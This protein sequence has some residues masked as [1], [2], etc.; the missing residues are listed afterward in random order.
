MSRRTPHSNNDGKKQNSKEQNR[1]NE[2]EKPGNI[3]GSPK[4]SGKAADRNIS[5][6]DGSQ[7][8]N[9]EKYPSHGRSLAIE[10]EKPRGGKGRGRGKSGYTSASNGRGESR[11]GHGRSN[12][13]GVS[14]KNVRQEQHH[15]QFNSN[16]FKANKKLSDHMSEQDVLISFMPFLRHDKDQ[17]AVKIYEAFQ[18]TGDH[19][20]F[21]QQARNLILEKRQMEAVPKYHQRHPKENFLTEEKVA[22]EE[23]SAEKSVDVF[24]DAI[25]P[26]NAE[27]KEDPESLNEVNTKNTTNDALSLQGIISQKQQAVL[28]Q[29]EEDIQEKEKAVAQC[30]KDR[31]SVSVKPAVIHSP[32]RIFRNQPG[33]ICIGGGVCM[34]VIITIAKRLLFLFLW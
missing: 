14:G 32:R 28:P 7:S 4:E 11:D 31:A 25:Q 18:T 29:K 2:D 16:K 23:K 30:V 6:E 26:T 12:L 20:T 9:F 8:R 22:Q 19:A 21:V 13:R 15:Q 5:G 33:T 24:N 27:E 1:K 34:T 17:E 10:E 3:Y